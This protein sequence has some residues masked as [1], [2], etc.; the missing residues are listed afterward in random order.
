MKICI[1]VLVFLLLGI[2]LLAGSMYRPLYDTNRSCQLFQEFVGHVRRAEWAEADALLET[3][4]EVFRIEDGKVFYR[5][6]DYTAHVA[7]AEPSFWNTFK[8]TIGSSDSDEKVIF[9]ATS[10]ADYAKLKD[11][12][13]VYIKMP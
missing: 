1:V 2:A 6:H 11:G 10:R 3:D 7:T 12:K 9:Q 4:P 5:N 8:N 13:I